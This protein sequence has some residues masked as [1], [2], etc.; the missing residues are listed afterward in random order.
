MS[1]L[2]TSSVQH[3]DDTGTQSERVGRMVEG[4]RDRG[5]GMDRGVMEGER[6]IGA[7]GGG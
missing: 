7:R 2:G 6:D 1:L 4:E 3:T 5:G